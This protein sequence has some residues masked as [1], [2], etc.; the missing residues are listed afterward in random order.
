MLKL[1][2]DKY[3]LF[4]FNKTAGAITM[5]GNIY[6]KKSYYDGLDDT[7]KEGLIIHE[8]VH[9]EQ[10]KTYGK[11]WYIKYTFSKAFRLTEELE[12]YSVEI[13]FLISK[14]V[15]KE[16]LVDQ[17]SAYLASDT[18]GHIINFVDAR[19]KLLEKLP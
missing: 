3:I 5:F 19:V 7:Q 4:L 13:K 14:G 11:K 16:R 2:G 17:Y 8:N 18:Y 15:N 12:A 9:L 1:V 6:I 10:Q